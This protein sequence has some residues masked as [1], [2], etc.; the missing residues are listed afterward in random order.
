MI[1]DALFFR[2]CQNLPHDCLFAFIMIHY[3]QILKKT[4]QV[5]QRGFNMDHEKAK[6]LLLATFQKYPHFHAHILSDGMKSSLAKIISGDHLTF[7]YMC[8]T[9]LLAK[10]CDPLI[11]LR[12]VQ[13]QSTLKSAYDARSLC[14]KVVVPFEKGMM[15]GR[16]GN[17][18][19]PYLNKPARC[20]SIEKGNPVRAGKDRDLLFCLYDLLE[21]LNHSNSSTQK[22]AFDYAFVLAMKRPPRIVNN[23]VLPEIKSDAMELN[24]KLNDFLM[25]SYEGQAPVAVFGALLKLLYNT[26]AI[27]VHPAN[28]AGAS[29]N[30]VGDIDIK[31]P[32]GDLYAVEVKDKVFTDTDVNHAT[33]KVKNSGYCRMI[34]ACGFN[35]GNDYKSTFE[36]ITYWAKEGVEL[37]FVCIPVLLHQV[38][39]VH[40]QKERTLLIH[41]ILQNL[42]EMRAKDIAIREFCE[43]FDL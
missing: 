37:S 5:K 40:G 20:V 29:S 36:R 33:E 1:A 11:H 38:I 23:I 26:A 3:C 13:S 6:E 27:E 19:E 18:N 9:A 32:D 15:E 7:R 34:F 14:H 31:F 17:S 41:H 2:G 24:E 22:E 12:A 16:L 43:L 35:C 42:Y 4:N 39:T 10:V 8:F 30:E 21:E 28:E 25:K